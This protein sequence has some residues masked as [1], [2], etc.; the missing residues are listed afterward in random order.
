[1]PRQVLTEIMNDYFQQS[2]PERNVA[3]FLTSVTVTSSPPLSPKSFTWEKVSD[4]NRFMK[5]FEFES[6][7]EMSNFVQEMLL[8]QEEFDHYAK[9]TV[10][11]PKVVIEV[12]TH[13]V[14]N[15]T[16][17]DTDYAKAA[18]QIRK[19]VFDYTFTEEETSYEF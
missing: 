14:N 6:H 10:D 3:G 15:I 12:Y 7:K 18:D 4:P 2:P 5:T 13:D 1:M 19:D 9:M 16:E 11:F 8:F 17:L